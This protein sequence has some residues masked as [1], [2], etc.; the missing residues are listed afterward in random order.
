MG[1]PS[2]RFAK[3]LEAS[4]FVGVWVVVFLLMVYI[5]VGFE[6]VISVVI[7]LVVRR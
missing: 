3:A 1:Y 4:G 2:V 7:A 5:V 6:W